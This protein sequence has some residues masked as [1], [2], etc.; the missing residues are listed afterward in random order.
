M[1]ALLLYLQLARHSGVVYQEQ[2]LGI[3]DK[4]SDVHVA[5]ADQAD[6]IVEG[7]QSF[8]LHSATPGRRVQRHRKPLGLV[9]LVMMVACRA[10]I[11]RRA[12]TNLA[13]VKFM[14]IL[15]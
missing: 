6:G 2:M 15:T 11:S 13:S 3:E 10:D 12:I 1:Y 4:R 7:E 9:T 14:F 8:R 5:H